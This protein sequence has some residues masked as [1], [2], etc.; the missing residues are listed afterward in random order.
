MNQPNKDYMIQSLQIQN[1][2]NVI[3]IAER[4]AMN[5]QYYERIIELE[6]E[7]EEIRKEQISE[8]D[9]DGKDG[10]HK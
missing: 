2:E 6:K 4:D 7:L 5:T 8:M 3:K 1:S 9:E 10:G